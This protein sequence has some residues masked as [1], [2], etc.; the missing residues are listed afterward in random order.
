MIHRNFYIQIV[1]RILLILF[2]GWAFIILLNR[3]ERFFTLIFVAFLVVTQIVLLVQ[4]INSINRKVYQFF[5]SI[6]NR[7]SALAISDYGMDPI[8]NK[9]SRE[10]NEVN[11]YISAIKSDVEV[12]NHYFKKVI[13]HTG[14]GLISFK[15]DGHVDFINKEAKKILN[16][17][18]LKQLK[19]LVKIDDVLFQILT[20]TKG[21]DQHV[22]KL[23][24][25][26]E[27]V[28]VLLRS[29]EFVL[30]NQNYKL[31]SLQNITPELKDQELDSWQKL[32]RVLTHEIFNTISP[33]SSLA[34]SLCTLYKNANGDLVDAYEINQDKLEKTIDGLEII[35]ERGKGLIS[36]VEKYRSITVLPQIHP[37]SIKVAELLHNMEKLFIENLR[38]Q[39]I[40][41]DVQVVPV[42]LKIFADQKFIEQVL[43]NLIQNALEA[44][45]KKDKIINLH[46]NPDEGGKNTVIKII[47]N[48]T[49]IKDEDLE[50]IFTPFFTT[51]TDGSGIGL[52][53]AQQVMRLHQ[54]NI[55]VNSIPGEGT[56][57]TLVF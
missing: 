55:S 30:D 49:G 32:I 4:Y 11:R 31:V 25:K 43:I 15:E 14:I 44:C 13:D 12:K 21:D 3:Q 36:F 19:D 10:L 38:L 2:T 45:D 56:T 20:I 34:D 17:T 1:S 8:S 53:L 7:D 51:K 6:R 33:L 28:K 39:N 24:Q 40:H 37:E 16:I 23:I 50:N 46:A 29:T 48:G 9:L 26:N 42:N 22:V 57:F 18:N 47:D 54:G 52:S 27:I 41:F 5:S 35:S